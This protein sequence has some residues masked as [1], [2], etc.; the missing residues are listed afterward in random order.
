MGIISTVGW[1]LSQPRG[2]TAV[3][4]VRLVNPEY[5]EAYPLEVMSYPDVPYFLV[6]TF[7]RFK[8]DEVLSEILAANGVGD[9]GDEDSTSQ[10]A[11]RRQILSGIYNNINV[12]QFR[13]TDMAEITASGRTAAEAVNL[14]NSIARTAIQKWQM[15]LKAEIARYEKEIASLQKKLTAEKAD[16]SATDEPTIWD[17]HALKIRQLR[18]RL[19]V[20]SCL[21]FNCRAELAGSDGCPMEVVNFARTAKPVPGFQL[22][23]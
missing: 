6:A 12:S 13:G 17:R 21:L 5:P 3:A 2:Y 15:A 20:V 16:D 19:R 23:L 10:S 11:G 9:L 4:L 7:E 18:N 22:S 8:S 14:A 1:Y